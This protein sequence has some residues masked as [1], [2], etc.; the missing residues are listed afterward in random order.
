MTILQTVLLVFTYIVLFLYGLK[1]FSKEI[2][3][4]GAERMKQWLRRATSRSWLG[5]L[6][7]ALFTA[8]IQ[9]SSAVSAMTVAMVDA[10]AISFVNSLGVL[11]GANVGTTS[12]AWLVSMKLTQIGPI[13]I[14]MGALISTLPYRIQLVGKSLFYFGFILF[15]LQLL[16]DSLTP[17]R[18]SPAVMSALQSAD[19]VWFAALAGM[20]ITALVQSSS[21]VSGLAIILI[22]NQL[23]GL[24]ESVAI[25]IGSNVG[26]TSTALIASVKLSAAAKLSAMANFVFNLSGTLLFLPLI[27]PLSHLVSHISTTPAYQVAWA[28]IIFNTSVAVIFLIILKPFSRALLR[29]RPSTGHESEPRSPQ[30]L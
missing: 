18:E 10:G 8:V 12:T 25:I 19:N 5:F 22:Q 14:V 3:E 20:L 28:H 11:L 13:F 7:G 29:W 21:V 2:Q 6:I 30:E 27:V 24:E 9:S 4:A 26:T 23:I 16:S 15:T 17:L 1:A